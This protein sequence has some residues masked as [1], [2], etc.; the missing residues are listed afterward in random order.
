MKQGSECRMN[1]CEYSVFNCKTDPSAGCDSGTRAVW[2]MIMAQG[3]P[4]R[5]SWGLLAALLL[6]GGIA[7]SICMTIKAH[8]YYDSNDEFYS[9]FSESHATFTVERTGRYEIDYDEDLGD[10]TFDVVESETGTP[11]QVQE[12]NLLTAL[13]HTGGRRG[14]EFYIERPGNYELQVRP[15]PRGAEVIVSSLDTRA[16][17][18][19][20]VGGIVLGGLPIGIGFLLL[21]FA[22]VSPRSKQKSLP[23]SSEESRVDEASDC[24]RDQ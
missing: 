2:G 14:H 17:A 23:N 8:S 16:I 24:S 19:W 6:A 11:V 10:L 1:S 13:A 22:I 9:P 4:S 18:L 7:I 20:S 21:L 5:L 3:K 15:W 12:F